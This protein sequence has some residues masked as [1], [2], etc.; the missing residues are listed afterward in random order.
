MSGK[1]EGLVEVRGQVVRVLFTNSETGRSMLSCRGSDGKSFKLE[2]IAAMAVEVGQQVSAWASVEMHPRYGEQFKTDLIDEVLPVER[3]AA[4]AYLARTLEGVD[5][6]LAERMFDKFGARIY[7]VLTNESEL[8]LQVHGVNDTKLVAIDE[9]WEE[10]SVVRSLWTHLAHY[11]GVNPGVISKIYARFGDRAMDVVRLRPYE[12]AKIQGVGLELADKIAMANGTPSDSG[13][14]IVGAIGHILEQA[15]Q[16]GHTSATVTGMVADVAKT[17]QFTTAGLVDKIRS[18]VDVLVERGELVLRQLDGEDCLTV[19]GAAAVERDIAQRLFEL[20]S[21]GSPD[22]ELADRARERAA[23]LKDEGQSNA[24]ANAFL[25]Q[26][27]VLTGGPGCGKTTVTKVIADVAKEAGL[28]V[29]MCAPTGKA[30]ART[31]EATGFASNTIHSLLGYKPNESGGMELDYH[32]GNPLKGDFFITDES[33]MMDTV[34][35]KM[36]LDALPD[37]ARLLIV[38]DDNQLPSVQPGNTLSDVIYSNT[39]CVSEL[40]NPHRA[41]LDSDITV[42]AYRIIAG[43]VEGVDLK[44]KKDFQF[45]SAIEDAEVVK[46]SVAQYVE[47]VKKH[48]IENT[49]LLV[50]RWETATGVH[51]LNDALRQVMNPPAGSKPFVEVMGKQLRLGDRVIRTSNNKQLKVTNGEV[52]TITSVDAVN[53][54]V[55]V[56]FS[57]REVVHD[58]EQLAAIDLAY[59]ITAHK[60]QGS[61]YAGV[62]LVMPRSQKFMLNRNLFYTALTRGKKDVRLVGSTD[63]VRAA[64]SRLGSVRRTGLKAE[65]A[66]VFGVTPRIRVVTKPMP[67]AARAPHAAP[68]AARPSARPA[69][70]PSPAHAA[71]AKPF[72]PYRPASRGSIVPQ[73]QESAAVAPTPRPQPAASGSPVRT[74]IIRRAP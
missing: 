16:Q 71:S 74:S 63:A 21:A 55:V 13:A 10:R 12:I 62:V 7:E 38:G 4:I 52:G 56:S 8:L 42:N 53:K 22:Q 27:S 40:K 3:R 37:G 61:E 66:R 58:R 41:A 18:V 2:G 17:L 20:A 31:T 11:D 69:P 26:V 72:V 57:D 30:A 23:G 19:K 46:A 59:A 45:I 25:N 32:R 65:L 49:Q 29:V 33:S 34:V 73:R 68:A 5:A 54:S 28:H 14:R 50:S 51:A 43:D 6:K 70:A 64:V 36:F 47:M 1:A 67:A 39:V 60:S 44:G 15:G 9:S 48:G 35:T 24:V